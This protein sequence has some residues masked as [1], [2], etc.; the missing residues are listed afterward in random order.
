M[1]K[2][3]YGFIN[4]LAILLR[5][6]ACITPDRWAGAVVEPERRWRT[7]DWRNKGGSHMPKRTDNALLCSENIR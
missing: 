1:Q 3:S 5:A 4:I 7:V 2:K 6:E